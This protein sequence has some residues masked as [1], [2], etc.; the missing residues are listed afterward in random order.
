MKT[1]SGQMRRTTGVHRRDGREGAVLGMAMMIVLLVGILAWGLLRV[2]E[3]NAVEVGKGVSAERAFWAAEAGR[4]H[5]RVFL[6]KNSSF[7]DSPTTIAGTVSNAVY[8]VTTIKLATNSVY[9][10]FSTGKVAF[11]SRAVYQEVYCAETIPPAF[12]YALFGGSG[13]MWIKKDGAFVNGDLFQW[14]D[15]TIAVSPN[16]PTFSSNSDASATGTIGD[17]NSIPVTPVPDPPPDFPPLDTSGYDALIATAAASGTNA[18]S[19]PL[20]LGGKTN[21]VKMATVTINNNIT[22]SGVLVVSGDVAINSSPVIGNNVM[23]VAGGKIIVGSN[24]STGTNVVLYSTGGVQI[25]QNCTITGY[26]M[27]LTSGDFTA[28]MN[29]TFQGLIYVGGAFNAKKNMTVIGSVLSK[30]GMQFDKEL[31]VTY[32]NLMK[33]PMPMGFS[34]VVVMTNGVWKQ[35]M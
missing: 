18:V 28:N 22:G 15:V 26:S 17:T 34:S 1:D 33:S 9:A 7:R 35:V 14:G 24:Y 11:A 8:G 16:P 19:F 25:S 4:K 12:G 2:G 20:A 5:A 27:L 23:I 29:L 10:I 30:N 21:Y 6:Y 13:L 3:F 31:N 32:T